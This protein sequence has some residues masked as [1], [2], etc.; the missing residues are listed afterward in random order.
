ME[1][2]A[3]LFKLRHLVF[4]FCFRIPLLV[5]NSKICFWFGKRRFILT[6]ARDGSKLDLSEVNEGSEELGWVFFLSRLAC[7]RDVF[8]FSDWTTFFLQSFLEMFWI[9]YYVR[10]HHFQA[11]SLYWKAWKPQSLPSL[12]V[13][14]IGNTFTCYSWRFRFNAI[15]AMITQVN[16]H[17]HCFFHHIYSSLLTFPWFSSKLGDWSKHFCGWTENFVVELPEWNLITCLSKTS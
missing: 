8:G 15:G 6:P 7:E 12:T 17:I 13:N 16:T 4:T 5:H 3:S 9:I 10:G 11:C 14:L 2:F 1:G